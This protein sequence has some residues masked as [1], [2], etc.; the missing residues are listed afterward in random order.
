MA[1]RKYKQVLIQPYGYWLTVFSDWGEYS[2]EVKKRTGKALNDKEKPAGKTHFLARNGER[3][4][5]VYA[6]DDATLAH[7]LT[8]VI[9]MIFEEIGSDPRESNGE[10]AAYLMSYLWGEFVGKR[11][12]MV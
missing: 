8:H 3:L 10:P 11:K 2:K 1:G 7:E 9:L 6:Q 12:F 5:L 4:L